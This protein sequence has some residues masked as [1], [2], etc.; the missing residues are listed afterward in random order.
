MPV[1]NIVDRRTND[2]N[3]Y[4]DA[5]FEPTFHDNSIEGATYVEPTNEFFYDQ[6]YDTTIGLAIV[7]ASRWTCPV[8]IFLYD[9]GS[10][11]GD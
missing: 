3:F 5:I 8:T 9:M 10:K 7:Y 2:H 4:V 1:Y 11:P 6:I